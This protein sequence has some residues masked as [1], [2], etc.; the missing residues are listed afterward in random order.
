[1]LYVTA[2]SGLAL[3]LLF[4]WS[5]RKTGGTPTRVKRVLIIVLGVGAMLALSM[6]IVGQSMMRS[7]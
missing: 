6:A 3:L 2:M 5:L 4:G 1:M 7:H